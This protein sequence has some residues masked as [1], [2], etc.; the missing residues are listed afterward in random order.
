MSRKV[1]IKDDWSD[2]WEERKKFLTSSLEAGADGVI[3]PPEDIEKTRKLGNIKVISN[4]EESDVLMLEAST[5][6]EVERAISKIQEE[7]EKKVALTVKISGKELEKAAVEAGKK[8]D[9]LIMIAQDWKVIPLENLIAE[10]QDVK[11]EVFAG[12]KNAQ[13][14]KTAVE[15]L[16]VGAT[17]VLLDPRNEGVEEIRK[18]CETLEELEEKKIQLVSAEVTKIEP[19]GMGDRACVDTASLMKIG[20]GMLVGSQSNGLFLVHSETLESE[21]VESR[22]FRV[23]AGAVHAYIQIPGGKTKYLSELQSGDKVLIV[24]SEGETSAATVGRVKIERRPMILIETEREDRKIRTLLQNAETINLVDKNGD[25]ISVSKL[26]V[27]DEVL[28]NLQ[29]GGRHFGAQVEE[30][31]IEK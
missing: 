22:P 30:T 13:E 5:Q 23:N 10:L 26:E 12:V 18:T 9:F 8:V 20:E 14:A 31:L 17:G 1:W 4:S 15:T 27:G 28:V 11:A 6:D 19:S 24:N 29:E 3:I 2:S 25:P 21:Y 7:K 16:E